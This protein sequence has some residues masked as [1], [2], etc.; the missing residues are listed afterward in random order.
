MSEGA[1]AWKPSLSSE[2]TGV[3]MVRDGP[4]GDPLEAGLRDRLTISGET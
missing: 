4:D 1:V 2:S 3:D